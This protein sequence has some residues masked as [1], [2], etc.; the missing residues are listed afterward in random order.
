M[1]Y[2]ILDG[3]DKKIGEVFAKSDSEAQ[4]KAIEIDKVIDAEDWYV[5]KS[6][7]YWCNN[8]A[9]GTDYRD[10]NGII[11]KI[12]T[13]KKCFGLSTEHLRKL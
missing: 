8:E 10:F 2:I 9:E 11:N 4:D 6:K 1:K 13:C 3:Y 7:C 5:R 12:P